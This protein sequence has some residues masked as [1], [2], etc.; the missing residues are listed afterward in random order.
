[1]DLARDNHLPIDPALSERVRQASAEAGTV[2]HSV[3]SFARGL[4]TGEPDDL[5]GLAGTAVGDLFVFGDIRDAVRDSLG[6]PT[7]QQ[8]DELI[9]GLAGVGPR[10]HSRDL[11][12]CPVLLPRR[13]LSHCAQGRREN[14]PDWWPDGSLADRRSLREV[15]DGVR[16]PAQFAAPA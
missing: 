9:L 16:F 15:V 2:S 13:G 11:R 12:H 5:A 3:D 14:R 4:F 10:C 6:L 7:G 8:A 1:V